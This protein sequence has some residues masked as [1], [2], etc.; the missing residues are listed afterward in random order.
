MR[1]NIINIYL[2]FLLKKKYKC[3]FSF[4]SDINFILKISVLE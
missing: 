1:V 4:N 3:F 2:Y